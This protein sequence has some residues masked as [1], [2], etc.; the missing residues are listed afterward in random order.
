MNT[1]TNSA[2][3][4]GKKCGFQWCRRNSPMSCYFRSRSWC[5]VYSPT[6]NPAFKIEVASL[7]YGSFFHPIIFLAFHPM[8]ILSGFSVYQYF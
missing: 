4:Y 3:M 5:C 7:Q 8:Q 6:S 1:I 2:D